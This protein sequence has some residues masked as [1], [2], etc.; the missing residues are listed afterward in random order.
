MNWSGTTSLH[1]CTLN[2]AYYHLEK[3]LR[4]SN[5]AYRGKKIMSKF[6]IKYEIKKDSHN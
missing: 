2:N 6:S 3:H 1:A 5:W 4:L